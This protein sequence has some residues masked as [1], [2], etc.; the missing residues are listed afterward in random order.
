MTAT[1]DQRRVRVWFGKHVL[2]EYD[3]EPERAQRYASL[4]EQRYRGLRVTIDD[5]PPNDNGPSLPDPSL[6]SLTVK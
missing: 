3:A 6:W 2:T 1:T 5:S 4:T